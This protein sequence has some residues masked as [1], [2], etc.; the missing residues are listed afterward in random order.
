MTRAIKTSTNRRLTASSQCLRGSTASRTLTDPVRPV[1]MLRRLSFCLFFLL[2]STLSLADQKATPACDGGKEFPGECK[3]HLKGAPLVF[4][5]NLSDPFSKP[6]LQ[7]YSAK[8]CPSNRCL[9]DLSDLDGKLRRVNYSALLSQLV[10]FVRSEG[11]PVAFFGASAGE[12]LVTTKPELVDARTRYYQVLLE[13]ESCRGRVNPDEICSV[14]G[15]ASIVT[16]SGGQHMLS[17][18]VLCQE[19]EKRILDYLSSVA[20]H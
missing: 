13:S 20:T 10:G 5:S 18:D 12:L 7:A 9:L 8:V 19:V 16:V 1:K 14:F 6:V 17:T 4:V 3:T 2:S 15:G 11:K